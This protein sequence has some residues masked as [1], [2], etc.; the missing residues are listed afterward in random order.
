M[1]RRIEVAVLS[2]LLAAVATSA[3]ADDGSRFKLYLTGAFGVQSLD[4]SGT[5]TF[6]EF[7]EEGQVAADYT[8]DSGPGLEGGLSYRLGSHLS[9]AL[10]G[11]YLKRDGSASY[12]ANLPHPLYL[13]KDRVVSDNVSGLDYNEMA[14]HLDL[15]VSGRSGSFDFSGFAGP[16]V[17]KVKADLIGQPTYTQS[18]PFDSVT[19]TSVPAASAQ[20]TAIGFNVGAGLDYR[21]SEKFA[22]GVQARFSRGTAKLKPE[23]GSDEIEVDA[24]GLQVG[25]GIRVFF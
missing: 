1:T 18:Y 3:P 21:L 10:M 6:T 7:A 25:A 19:V 17:F 4:F 14:G 23:G 12:Q 24:G 11:S 9:V 13:D 16:S 22:L 2:A 5:R 20:K 15:V 8:E